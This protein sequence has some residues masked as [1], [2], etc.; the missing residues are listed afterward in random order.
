MATK[1]EDYD[2]MSFS[3]IDLL[4]CPFVDLCR[5]PKHYFLCRP[6]D[7]KVLCSEYI[8]KAKVL[9]NNKS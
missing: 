6:P 2:F 3:E 5:L 4:V 7:C 1:S 9:N 8:S